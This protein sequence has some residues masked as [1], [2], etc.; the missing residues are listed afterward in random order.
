MR[1]LRVEKTCFSK[2]S[3]AHFSDPNTHSGMVSKM[4]PVER[5]KALGMLSVGLSIS[6]VARRLGRNKTSIMR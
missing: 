6:E 1:N 2:I 3:A 5:G 4:T